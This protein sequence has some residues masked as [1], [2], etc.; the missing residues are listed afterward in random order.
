MVVLVGG[1]TP[2]LSYSVV[3][4]VG[5]RGLAPLFFYSEVVGGP[6]P[7]LSYSVVAVG[8]WSLSPVLLW[9]WWVSDP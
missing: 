8:V 6:T 4:V 5:G 3:V 1:P 7:G 2:G 9:W